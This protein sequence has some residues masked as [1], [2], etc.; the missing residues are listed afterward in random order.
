[1]SDVLNN[2][3]FPQEELDK[4]LKQLKT[5]LKSEKTNPNSIAANISQ[6]YNFGE[7][8]PYGEIITEKTAENVNI[9]NIKAYYNTYFKPNVAYLVI[10]GDIKVKEAKKLSKKY[11]GKWKKAEV[12]SHTYASPAKPAE[13]TVILS[14]IDAATQSV[15]NVTFPVEYNI[16]SE[17]YLSAKIMN[18]ILG[19]G[20]FSG[21]LFQNLREKNAW[22]YGAYSNLS[23][24][25]LIGNFKAYSQV[26]G[27]ATDSAINEILFEIKRL[28]TELVEEEL[29]SLVKNGMAGRFA[30]SLERPQTVARFAYN[31]EK[32]NLPKDFYNTYL[33]RLAEVTAEDV[34]KAA[35]K[36]LNTENAYLIA[37][38]N[39]DAIKESMIA[40]NPDKEIIIVDSYANVIKEDPNAVP[41]GLNAEM[42][43]EKYIEAIGGK[44]KLEGIKDITVKQEMSMM[45]QKVNQT[46]IQ[47][48]PHFVKTTQS[49]GGQVLAETI[50]NGKK[51]KIQSPMG[52]QEFTEGPQFEMVKLQATMN[53]ELKYAEL[54]YKLNLKGAEMIDGKKAYKV[55]IVNPAGMSAVD[56]YDAESGLKIKTVSTQGAANIVVTYNKYKDFNGI[57]QATEVEQ[58]YGPQSVNVKTIDV[59]INSNIED[60]VFGL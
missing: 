10:V 7:G 43:I 41:E 21:R 17:D 22:T 45:G 23:S 57:I 52:N 19:G 13:P 50:F 37:V 55:E 5:G 51:V 26:K 48:A 36:Y 34:Q 40:L 30:Q 20:S 31:I 9:E 16:T 44:A 12:P 29:L 11:F 47:K 33:E 3:V 54:N 27:E 53:I 49:M 35:Q 8:H 32:Y 15:I 25:E 38:G 1:M 2:P 14:N 39:V 6:V 59:I 28:K 46:T 58:S 56:F 18:S 60:S 24:D 42:V 4:Y